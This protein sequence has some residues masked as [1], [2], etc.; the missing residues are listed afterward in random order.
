[1]EREYSHKKYT[2][3]DFSFVESLLPRLNSKGYN[4]TPSDCTHIVL[5][6]EDVVGA[7]KF[8]KS[9]FQGED[10]LRLFW[11]AAKINSKGVGSC[12]VK[13]SSS[14]AR[15]DGFK[16]LYASYNKRNCESV[17]LFG[18]EVFEEIG[19]ISENNEIDSRKRLI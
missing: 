5:L 10:V 6:A 15:Q 13:T 2:Q 11:L 8:E 1:M 7:F 3:G 17:R 16:Y 9:D 12:I 19:Q 14:F 4:I 18:N